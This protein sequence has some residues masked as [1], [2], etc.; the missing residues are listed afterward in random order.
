M[1]KT[2]V[3]LDLNCQSNLNGEQPR[4]KPTQ[5]S[6]T[7][8]TATTTTTAVFLELH[9]SRT[10]P[11]STFRFC[12]VSKCLGSQQKKRGMTMHDQVE[13]AY[14]F[15][16]IH[17]I[18]TCTC[19]KRHL[20]R[21]SSNLWWLNFKGVVSILTVEQMALS[22]SKALRVGKITSGIFTEN[23][24]NIPFKKFLHGHQVGSDL[25]WL[26]TQDKTCRT[27]KIRFTTLWVKHSSGI[28]FL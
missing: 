23:F 28:D 21:S 25:V 16:R 9:Q 8:T 17:L 12:K 10:S 1:T 2:L 24:C 14:W 7:P 15:V 3:C 6:D 11:T 19:M 27:R 4:K 13:I 18:C 26:K 5:N 20:W 22:I